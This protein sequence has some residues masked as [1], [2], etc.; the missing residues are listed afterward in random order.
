LSW[1]YHDKNKRY[2]K[3]RDSDSTHRPGRPRG[4]GVKED[5]IITSMGVNK[6]LKDIIETYQTEGERYCDTMLRIYRDQNYRIIAL[7]KQLEG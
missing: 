4:S 3:Y 7:K 1:A 5:K 2:G 6:E